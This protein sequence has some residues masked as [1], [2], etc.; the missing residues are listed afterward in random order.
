MSRYFSAKKLG[1]YDSAIKDV[2]DAAG[3]WPADA[4]SVTDAIWE[5]YTSTPEV[6]KILSSDSTGN[7][8]W[9]DTETEDSIYASQYSLLKSNISNTLSAITA[10]GLL[11]PIVAGCVFGEALMMNAVQ[12][13]VPTTLKSMED[14]SGGLWDVESLGTKII[15]VIGSVRYAAGM[16][17]GQGKI[18]VEAL[19]ALK[20]EVDS[21]SKTLEDLK[22]FDCSIDTPE[23]STVDLFS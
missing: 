8:C 19:K 12:D 18:K 16:V 15:G 17:L 7:P 22:S 3:T 23:V 5:E 20:E 4:V 6:G 13:Y 21:G 2:Y 14:N 10:C 11:N 1:F 9:E